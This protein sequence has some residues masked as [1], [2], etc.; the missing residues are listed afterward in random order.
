MVLWF[1]DQI[2]MLMGTGADVLPGP[3][4]V[5]QISL[6]FSSH[7]PGKKKKKKSEKREKQLHI[8]SLRMC[9]AGEEVLHNHSKRGFSGLG[10]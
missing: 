9:E 6:C 2:W 7:C 3:S 10:R 1:C 8:H 5:I 4:L